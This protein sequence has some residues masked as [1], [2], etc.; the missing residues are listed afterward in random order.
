MG[1]VESFRVRGVECFF[2]S[3][4]PGHRPHFHAKRA[5]EWEIRVFFM[6]EPP[7]YD[8]KL[9]IRHIPGNRRRQ[10]L[11]LASKHRE[12]LF[13]EWTRKALSDE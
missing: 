13:E 12:A 2:Y 8:V 4:E 11:D 6:E 1:K 9:A 5:G 10:L 7:E 3:A